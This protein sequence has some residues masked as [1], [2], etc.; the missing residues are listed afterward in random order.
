M[1]R[2][3]VASAGFYVLLLALFLV[4]RGGD[5]SVL[6]HAGDRFTDARV[7]PASL[8][9]IP[10]SSG[11]DGQFY[12]AFALD[13]WPAG[14][15]DVVRGIQIDNPPHRHQ[16]ILYPLLAHLV[17]FGGRAPLVPWAL[18]VVNLAAFA[19]LGACGTAYARDL[20]RAP[21]WGL[22]FAA[23]P[24]LF[25]AFTRDLTDPL[26]CA[27]QLAL[28]CALRRDRARTAAALACLTVLARE[29]S[30]VLALAC[31]AAAPFAVDR[32]RALLFAG[33]AGLA[34]LLAW[35]SALA[36]LWGRAPAATGASLLRLPPAGLVAFLQDPSRHRFLDGYWFAGFALLLL[37]G[38]IVV[39]AA[40]LSAAR[41][42]ERL[43]GAGFFLLA[44]S[45]EPHIWLAPEAFFRASSDLFLFATALLLA[46]EWRVARGLWAAAHGGMLSAFAARWI[47]R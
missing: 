10:R 31:L 22:L 5:V 11:F 23:S 24:S 3:A 36:A 44:L 17:S 43:A 1:L 13:P 34:T 25:L 33:G 21:A 42:W 35:Q 41:I 28:L 47:M 38:G 4:P 39:A 45:L 14:D 15:T 32:R 8:R 29:S 37:A 16:R 26:A 20:G 40:D 30:L 9:V 46:S 18:V 27:L 2:A 12:Y 7:A 6:V 19:L